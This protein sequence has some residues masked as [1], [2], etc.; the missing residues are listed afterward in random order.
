MMLGRLDDAIPMYRLAIR[1]QSDMLFGL[2]VALDRDEQ[3]ETAKDYI[4]DAGQTARDEFVR[5][6]S[7]QLFFFVPEGEGFYYEALIE[8]ANGEYDAAIANWQHFIDSGAHAQYQPRAKAHIDALHKA[9]PAP[10]RTPRP[11]EL[12]D[13]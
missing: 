3:G 12:D 5:R 9:R 4:L 1:G 11:L 13:E 2:A 7:E 10:P 6:V 8:E